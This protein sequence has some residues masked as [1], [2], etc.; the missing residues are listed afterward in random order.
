M[1]EKI[2][3]G[4]GSVG[5]IAVGCGSVGGITCVIVVGW[6]SVKDGDSV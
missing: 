6:I 1:L 4:C 2:A 3:V 5:K